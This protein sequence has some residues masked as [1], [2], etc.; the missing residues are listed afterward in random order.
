MIAF[1]FDYILDAMINVQKNSSTHNMLI[2][3]NIDALKA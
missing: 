3:S 1:Y 2:L